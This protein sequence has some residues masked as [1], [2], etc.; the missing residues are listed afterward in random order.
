MIKLNFFT[1]RINLISVLGMS[2]GI[3]CTLIVFLIIQYELTFDAHNSKGDNIFRMVSKEKAAERFLFKSHVPYPLANVLRNETSSVM[4]TTQVLIREYGVIKFKTS[5]GEHKKIEENEIT[6]TD[7]FYTDVFDLVFIAGDSKKFLESPY[8]VILTIKEVEKL[9]GQVESLNSL[10]GQEIMI[11]ESLHIISGIVKSTPRNTNLPFHVLANLQSIEFKTPDILRDWSGNFRIDTYILTARRTMPKDVIAD[12]DKLKKKYI[13]PEQAKN[14][15]Y[16]LQPLS[17]IH[18]DKV[19]RQSSYYS[20]PAI[21]IYALIVLAAFILISASI[22]YISLSVSDVLKKAKQIGIRKMLGASNQ[23]ILKKYF[24]ESLALMITAA[25]IGVLSTYL[26]LP[27]VNGLVKFFDLGF[28]INGNI[29]FP[30]ILLIILITLLAGYFPASALLSIS[31]LRIVSKN[32]RIS[33]K[34]TFRSAM[35]GIQFGIS[36]LLIISAFI[37]FDQL[38]FIKGSDLGYQTDH[39]IL[40]FLNDDSEQ[41]QMEYRYNLSKIQNVEDV[42]FNSG[43]PTSSVTKSDFFYDISKGD[44]SKIKTEI[45]EIDNHYFDLFGLKLVAGGNMTLSDKI[46]SQDST[47]RIINLIVNQKAVREDRS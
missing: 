38:K 36:Q 6:Y 16:E 46:E 4:A 12:L 24:L 22:N 18:S 42:S 21:L 39:K 11:N 1:K 8:D 32:V 33:K 47:N 37:I 40:V 10:I 30:L 20:S 27:S 43:P 19:Y 9:F 29:V 15:E 41:K 13:E 34:I 14:I 45:K 35:V 2:V 28:E 44:G 5:G 17:S 25:I 7:K 31:P 3:C 26:L 23:I